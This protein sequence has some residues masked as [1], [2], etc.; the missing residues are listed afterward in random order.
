MIVLCANCH[1]RKKNTSDPRHINRASL[2]KIK[3]NLML[4][5]GRFSDLERRIIDT[6]REEL[7]AT[8]TELPSIFIPERLNLLV[9][10]LI[11]DALVA[12]TRY[13]SSL[14]INFPDGTVLRDDNLKL[15]LTSKGKR[16]IDELDDR[17]TPAP[18]PKLTCPFPVAIER[19]AGIETVPCVVLP[20]IRAS[21]TFSP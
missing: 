1:A 9:R 8:P 17:I 19:R 10:Y 3:S 20:L 18:A 12:T 6:F 13:N 14:S 4:L 7:S 16:F 5:N 21:P 15:T 2:Q 11:S